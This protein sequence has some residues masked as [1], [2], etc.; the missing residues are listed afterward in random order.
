MQHRAPRVLTRPAS[1]SCV[2]RHSRGEVGSR[3]YTASPGLPPGRSGKGALE[4]RRASHS[5][6][7]AYLGGPASLRSR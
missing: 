7:S 2:A 6:P 4:C 3:I 1:S 5:W